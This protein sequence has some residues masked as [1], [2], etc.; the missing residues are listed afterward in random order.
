M[1]TV[2]LR[3]LGKRSTYRFFALG[4]EALATLKACDLELVPVVDEA[5]GTLGTQS[6]KTGAGASLAGRIGFYHRGVNAHP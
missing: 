6:R 1:I 4:T 5:V 2:M 3:S